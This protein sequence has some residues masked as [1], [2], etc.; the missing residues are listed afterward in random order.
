MLVPPSLISDSAKSELENKILS[1]PRLNQVRDLFVFCCYTGL[2]YQEMATLTKKNIVTKFDD[3]L[4]IDIYR[5]KT[6]KQL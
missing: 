4:W 3:R 5:N 6:K 2:P 1:Q